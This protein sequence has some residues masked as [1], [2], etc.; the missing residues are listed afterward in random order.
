[1]KFSPLTTIGA[2]TVARKNLLN[3]VLGSESASND[4]T[5]RADYA[6]KGASGKMKASLDTLAESAKKLMEG[7]VIV[8]IDPGL[9]DVS[10]IND[11]L[12]GDDDAFQALKQTIEI[13]GQNT[14]VLLRPH[15]D[16]DGRYMIVFGHRR[17][18]VAAELGRPIRAVIKHVDDVAHVLAQGQ[19]NTARADLSFI[20]KALFAK[21]LLD[22]GH[23]NEIIQAALTIDATLLSRMLSVS[24]RV[25]AEMIEAIGPAKTVGR[26]RWEQ[27]K[28]LVIEPSNAKRANEISAM[29]D[30]SLLDSDTRFELLLSELTQKGRAPRRTRAKPQKQSWTAGEGKVK[31]VYGRSGRAFSISLTSDDA[32]DFGSYIAAN[33]DALYRTFKSNQKGKSK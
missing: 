33:L 26:D 28:R 29:A 2:A 14:P 7:E 9:V 13:H 16:S 31:G 24:Q 3:S 20:E 25:P 30:F 22:Y 19:E 21:R 23:P 5:N 18:R 11:R 4:K 10:F 6:L 15:P 17:V 12:T 32:T 27:F 8:E 1:M